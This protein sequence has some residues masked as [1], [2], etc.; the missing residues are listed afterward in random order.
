MAAIGAEFH[1]LSTKF[2]VD[3]TA[4]TL[5]TVSGT[6]LIG[7]VDSIGDFDLSRN[8][9]EYNSYGNDYKKKLTGQADSGEI[10]IVCNWIPDAT[11]APNQALLKTYFD[12]GAK[13]YCGLVWEDPAGNQAGATF[14]AFV[15]SFAVS[16]PVEDVVKITVSLAID[17]A[18][19]LD[20]DGT[21]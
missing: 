16:Q 18:V 2:Y 12:S 14:E 10:E 5:A 8:V 20:V 4:I 21:L 17:G 1:G 6:E 3:T 7:S 19:A 13:I 11:A 9:I 15:A